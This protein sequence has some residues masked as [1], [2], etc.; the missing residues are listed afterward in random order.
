[1]I[2]SRVVLSSFALRAF[3]HLLRSKSFPNALV[4]RFV[5]KIFLLLPLANCK[6]YALVHL[7]YARP[8]VARTHSRDRHPVC[9]RIASFSD[10]SLRL[11]HAAGLS[12]NEESELRT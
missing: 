6:L 12:L 1:M 8:G 7:L 4:P 5:L 10:G 11:A 2:V 3:V 9:D